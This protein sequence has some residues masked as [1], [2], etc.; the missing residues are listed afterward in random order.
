MDT[1]DVGSLP[2]QAAST[3][4]KIL[5]LL[6]RKSPQVPR[7]A[8]TSCRPKEHVSDVADA[9]R[10]AEPSWAGSPGSV[11]FA[12]CI[13][14][15][16]NEKEV[17]IATLANLLQQIDPE[18]RLLVLFNGFE[19]RT[20]RMHMEKHAGVVCFES[21][22]NLGV[23]GGRNLLYSHVLKEE[24]TITHI[25]TIDNDVLL[26]NDLNKLAKKEVSLHYTKDVGVLGAV[27]LDYKTDQTREFIQNNFLCFKG[28]LSADCY[29]L[30][31]TD[32]Q[33]YLKAN[34]S[35][36]RKILWHIGMHPDYRKAYIENELN[37]EEGKEPFQGFLGWSD[38]V[39][40]LLA[41]RHFAVSN[42]AGCFQIFSLEHLRQAGLLEEKF[43][44]YFF[45][46]SEFCIRSIKM[47]KR[48]LI[49]TEL[50]LLH[51]TDLR[52]HDRQKVDRKHLHLMNEY[53][54]RYILLRRLEEPDALGKL[55]ERAK[56]ARD[57]LTEDDTARIRYAAMLEG[58][59]KGAS[60]YFDGQAAADLDKI[61]QIRTSL[62]TTVP[63]LL[64]IGN[65]ADDRIKSSPFFDD[66]LPTSDKPLPSTYFSRLKRFRNAYE[67]QDCLIVCN[68]PSLKKTRLGLFSGIPTF[69]VNSTFILQDSLGFR[70]DFYTVEDNHVVADNV[71]DIMSLKAGAKF[72]PEKYRS[73]IGD[74]DGTYY[75]PVNWDC[76]FKSK[77]SHE[78]PE[79]STDIGRT[80]FAGQ[81]VTYLNLQLAYYFGF[82]RV[83][84]VGLDFSYSIPKGS[85]VE[86]N[87]ID[88]D[89]DDPNHFH[90]SYFGKGKQWH[91]PKLDSCMVS[92]SI[93]REKFA[94]EGRQVIDLTTGGRLNVFRKMSVED[95]IGLG[96]DIP[97]VGG[98]LDPRQYIIDTCH[99]LAA[100]SGLK[101][102][103]SDSVPGDTGISGNELRIIN[104]VDQA[105]VV[106]ELSAARDRSLGDAKSLIFL[107]EGLQVICND[108]R[109]LN[110]LPNCSWINSTL[111]CMHVNLADWNP[112][113]S[114]ANKGI[115]V[116]EHHS[117]FKDNL[118]RNVRMA[119]HSS[120]IFIDHGCIYY[121]SD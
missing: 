53:R 78:Y 102:I 21:P 36:V 30:F 24:A 44:P 59:A 27:I 104:L 54:A 83:F 62:G 16:E 41:E 58:M 3:A 33:D 89:D 26:P 94:R 119:L 105:R 9:T 10:A 60:Q 108:I 1:L 82:Q 73:Q 48:N 56:C 121:H 81:T 69:A 42:V 8:D 112:G 66:S 67:G 38:S 109:L 76:Y 40:D 88:H 12:Y 55:I 80:I 15:M 5:E 46:D 25:V 100:R 114:L 95:A 2:P 98:G 116:F 7:E 23:A 117:D 103:Y 57:S 68:G 39:A 35:A 118:Q 107:K 22:V 20:L 72:F 64:A 113:M 65:P 63:S 106:S 84:I 115:C 45:E 51:G 29:N 19:D 110:R 52:H 79:F 85:K 14:V 50:F 13:L 6:G 37:N 74:E 61:A 28:Y 120:L 34:M 32:L 17:T 77:I 111:A 47:G 4:N 75:L 31:T 49:S 86:Q 91:F 101:C 87:S 43:S 90:P 96:H 93:A 71:A 18:D 92:Y 97:V 70:P 99:A 11:Q